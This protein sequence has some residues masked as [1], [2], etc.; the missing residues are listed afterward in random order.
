MASLTQLKVIFWNAGS[1]TEEKEINIAHLA[2]TEAADIIMLTNTFVGKEMTPFA[3]RSMVQRLER[4]TGN[5]WGGTTSPMAD[6][7]LG[8]AIVMYSAFIKDPRI[9][10][11]LPFGTLTEFG[12]SWGDLPFNLLSVQQVSNLVSPKYFLRSAA[13]NMALDKGI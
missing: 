7:C 6:D 9:D 2:Q 4:M 12:G 8:G 5:Q 1:W 13:T 3:T 10:Y 11:L